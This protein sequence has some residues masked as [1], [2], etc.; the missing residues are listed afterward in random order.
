MFENLQ[1]QKFKK[2]VGLFYLLKNLSS[3]IP[4]NK[5]LF[6]YDFDWSF[7]NSILGC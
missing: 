2:I 1:F 6:S 4:K 3:E 7:L 5:R